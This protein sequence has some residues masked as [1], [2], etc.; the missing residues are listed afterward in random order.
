MTPDE[1]R[2]KDFPIHHEMGDDGPVLDL[3]EIA[4]A[5]ESEGC[6]LVDVVRGEDGQLRIKT[7]CMQ[8]EKEDEDEPQDLDD[9]M[10]RIE[11][12]SRMKKMDDMDS[13]DAEVEG[14]D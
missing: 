2:A 12:Q 13:S 1:Y 11:K 3:G 7:V 6:M 4:A 5:I 9:A 14:D 8:G 10:T